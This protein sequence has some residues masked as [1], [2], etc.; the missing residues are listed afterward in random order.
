M[1]KQTKI[2]ITI[3]VT[4]FFVIG[5]YNNF[6]TEKKV[7][8]SNGNKTYTVTLQESNCN[9]I[10]EN[11]VTTI[12]K[13]NGSASTIV[14]NKEILDGNTLAIKSNAFLECGNLDTI[15]I[16]KNIANNGFKIENFEV[17]TEYQ[18]E[19][20][21]EYKNIQDYSEAYKLYLELSE[22][23]K[24]KIEIIPEK[25]DI[26]MSAMHSQSMQENYQL[27]NINEITLPESFD[28]RD[29][30]NI[31]VENQGN[32][33][34]C[35]AFASLTSVET[36]LA[37]RNNDY[38]DLS[39]SHLANN[40]YGFGSGSFINANNKYY[41]DKIGPVYQS[42]GFSENI[43]ARRYVKETV[44][45]PTINKSNTYTQEELNTARRMIKTHIMQYGSLY[46]SI[47]S[48]IKKNDNN[49]YVLN[50]EFSNLPDHAVSIIGWDDDFSKE[51]FPISNR[52][53]TDGAYLAVNSWGETWGDNGCFWISYEDTWV[54]SS[55]RGVIS[56]DTCQENMNIE[57]V[58]VTDKNNNSE[59]SYKITKGIN[60]QICIDVN[61]DEI[62]NNQEQ[63]EINVI[64]PN[65]EDIIDEVEISGNQIENNKAKILLGIN[66]SVLSTGE[67]IINIKYDDEI[68]LVPIVIKID[69]YDFEIK[70][71]G[72]INI[73]GYYGKDKKIIIPEEFFGFTVSGIKSGAFI[74]NDLESITVFGNITEIGENIIDTSVIIYGN[75]QTY[76]EQYANENEYIFIDLN[77]KVIE[78]QGWYFDAEEHKL[79]ITENSDIKEYDY[80]KKVIYK[81]EVKNSIQEIFSYQFHGYE[82][83]EEVILPE[84]V[85][86]IGEK[87]FGECYNLKVI[88]L[89]Q[90]IT[91][92]EAQTFYYCK[93]LENVNIPE[94]VTVIGSGAF[95]YCMNL[96]NINI[97]NGVTAISD[98]VFYMCGSLQN[99]N[100]PNGVTSIG[101][102]AFFRCVNLENINIPEGTT[103]IGDAAFYECKGLYDLNIPSS[104]T[105]IGS[106]VFNECI[107]NKVAEQGT[108]ELQLPNIIKR[109][110]STGDILNC[111]TGISVTN[112]KINTSKS[113]L[114]ITPGFGQILI[115]ISSGKLKGLKVSVIASGVIEYSESYWTYED[116]TATL[117]IGKGEYVVNNGGEP[118]YKFSE[119][120]EFEFEYVNLNGETV[121]ALVTNTCEH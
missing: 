86:V 38:V 15:L 114:E 87:A 37:L 22:Q 72:N 28:L 118:V 104:V 78:G 70:E 49:I 119:N 43:P 115:S 74:N 93:N 85:T 108:V 58:V 5:F 82:N 17:N 121:R 7:E 31:K 64:S 111:G 90:N 27:T 116:V 36:N 54:E 77:K 20:Y 52:P 106:N 19:Q 25:Y 62:I 69:T 4:I 30:I 47:S 75:T 14:I 112:G 80:L 13:Y 84:S 76:I 63:F 109:A 29:K 34:I 46:T 65:G 51:N 32:L 60:A 33:G 88:N 48:T 81:V 66:T 79:V 21:I 99:I 35:Y 10:T 113:T 103:N 45:L 16:D 24:N 73:T 110:I 3:M 50:A 92:L 91:R 12:E 8:S 83:L 94:G 18:D 59:I 26:Q 102:Y 95:Q 117:Y 39:E 1:K 68:L 100:I 53:K 98:Y 96:K 107:I 6:K 71:D 44:G 9:T 56:V 55:L 61:I 105:T 120:G 40:T 97:P 67:Y 101:S 57:D 89:P 41:K 2:V 11:N 23:E 42:D